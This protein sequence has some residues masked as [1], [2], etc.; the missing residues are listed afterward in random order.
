MQEYK[1]NRCEWKRAAVLDKF[2]DSTDCHTLLDCPVLTAARESLAQEARA[3]LENFSE[4]ELSEEKSVSHP[5]RKEEKLAGKLLIKYL[6]CLQKSSKKFSPSHFQVLA[7]S[8]PPILKPGPGSGAQKVSDLLN[9][10]HAS[11]THSGDRVFG[12]LGKSALGIDFE[13]QRDL[14]EGTIRYF[15]CKEERDWLDLALQDSSHPTFADRSFFGLILFTQKE[16]VLKAVGSGIA[17]GPSEVK[18][19]GIRIGVEFE[20]IYKE[21]KFQVITLASARGILSLAVEI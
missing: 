10:L 17:G 11:I 12:V 9:G 2:L 6:L 13:V 19:P 21:R 15:S 4:E 18:L 20:A 16:A 1:L 5:R 14:K 3:S 8:H 7:D